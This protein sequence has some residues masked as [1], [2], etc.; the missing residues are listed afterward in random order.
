[1]TDDT[2]NTSGNT[3]RDERVQH[4]RAATDLLADLAYLRTIFVNVFF[5]GPPSAPDRGWVLIDTGIPHVDAI[6]AAAAARFGADSR[7]SAIILTHGHFDHVGSVKQLM[8]EW[9][10]PVYAH[11]LELPYLTGEQSYPPP[12]PLAGGGMALLSVFYPRGPVDLTPR[13]RTLPDDGSVPGMPG[14][15]W[16]HTPG[17]T[18]GHVSLFR[19][20]DR[21]LIAGD[22]F[23][24][25]EQESVYAVLTQK[26]EVNG[27]P[28]YFTPDWNAA[29]ESVQ[30]LDALQP[31]LAATGHGVPMS[32]ADMVQQLD[33]LARNFDELAVPKHGR[34][35][36]E[37]PHEHTK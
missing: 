14:W 33:K 24:T 3:S 30:R 35:S 8:D 12:N 11:P 15:R 25:T 4:S 28:A 16:I 21:A 5:F 17:H 23:V 32:G 18:I 19:D 9:D 37:V 10:V 26:E 2:S 36:D 22:A 13:V 31:Y 29:R 34:Y 27:P 1:M 7:P 20:S 6:R